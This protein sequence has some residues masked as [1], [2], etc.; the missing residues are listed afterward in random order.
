MYLCHIYSNS[1]NVLHVLWCH[2]CH[3]VV[4]DGRQFDGF[5]YSRGYCTV[6]G[7]YEQNKGIS[8]SCERELLR[9]L[10]W[11]STGLL[12][13]FGTSLSFFFR[14]PDTTRLIPLH[15]RS[16]V[17]KRVTFPQL[18]EPLCV[19]E[20][21]FLSS[22][23]WQL[24]RTL[25]CRA[26]QRSKSRGHPASWWGGSDGA[27]IT[28]PILT[29][30][31]HARLFSNS[32]TFTVHEYFFNGGAQMQIQMFLA[33]HIFVIRILTFKN[34]LPHY[35]GGHQLPYVRMQ[36][37]LR[38]FKLV[39][40]WKF[41]MNYVYLYWTFARNKMKRIRLQMADE[42]EKCFIYMVISLS[43]FSW[44][45]PRI[46]QKIIAQFVQIQSVGKGKLKNRNVHLRKH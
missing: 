46:Y 3:A 31:T 22:R 40:Q 19:C 25:W 26:K 27:I 32:R 4:I 18:L 13:F 30:S 1:F 28:V 2:Y 9:F 43:K 5:L 37:K 36:Y 41:M 29:A 34:A 17:E 23:R 21:Q 24:Q 45:S 15:G 8:V 7:I 12:F 11:L 42:I 10:L 39:F 44:I 6:Y 16:F 20:Q 14:W 35:Y 38:E 33:W